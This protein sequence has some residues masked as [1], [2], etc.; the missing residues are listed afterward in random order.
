MATSPP[1]LT[2]VY[3]RRA[4]RDLDA[5]WDWNAER[6][7]AAQATDY[8]QFL[9]T[10]INGLATTYLEGRR[11][12]GFPELKQL[13]MRR[14][15]QG[16]FHIA[17]YEVDEVAGIVNILHVYHERQDISGRLEEERG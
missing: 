10:K 9:E 11:V 7:G 13:A 2:V 5:I 16:H 6:D 8:V 1:R 4:H 14:S 15:R 17:I 12:K 3:T